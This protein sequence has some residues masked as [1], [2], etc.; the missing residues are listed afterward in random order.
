[1]RAS[2]RLSPPALVLLLL[3]AWSALSD[4]SGSSTVLGGRSRGN[5]D[6][7]ADVSGEDADK[8]Q[9]GEEENANHRT[10]MEIVKHKKESQK[11]QNELKVLTE[12]IAAVKK[13]LE[14][15]KKETFNHKSMKDVEKAVAIAVADTMKSQEPGMDLSAMADSIAKVAKIQISSGKTS[16]PKNFYHGLQPQV[17]FRAIRHD[18]TAE[19]QP[20]AV[21]AA[22]AAPAAPA[23][24]AAAAAAAA[25]APA[26]STKETLLH[27]AAPA[28]NKVP[29]TAKQADADNA[30]FSTASSSSS[31][32]AAASEKA[33]VER[34]VKVAVAAARAAKQVRDVEG[35][36]A[37]Q[38]PTRRTKI[39][40]EQLEDRMIEAEARQQI[41]NERYEAKHAQQQQQ[42]EEQEH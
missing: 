41:D 17:S 27:P 26:S 21:A 28:A 7:P 15:P 2:P 14:T 29:P 12:K 9:D 5:S 23:A 42:Q 37:A 3:V 31:A 1:M 18:D 33:Q 13:K 24:P 8:P 6:D 10:Q 25:A 32:S 38:A 36:A 20:A 4:S 35:Y 16:I 19:A 40:K 30:R 34:A 11:L 39:D 22:V